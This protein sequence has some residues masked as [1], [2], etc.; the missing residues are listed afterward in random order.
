MLLRPKIGIPNSGVQAR[1]SNGLARARI[2][3]FRKLAASQKVTP[4]LL[5]SRASCCALEDHDTC[6][7]VICKENA[8]IEHGIEKIFRRK[9]QVIIYRA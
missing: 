3:V 1:I 6:T 4:F 5:W 9:L 7:V 2:L 8:A